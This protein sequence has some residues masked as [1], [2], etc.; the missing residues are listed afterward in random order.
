[1]MINATEIENQIEA[2]RK[3]KEEIL[4]MSLKNRVDDEFKE[5]FKIKILPKINDYKIKCKMLRQQSYIDSVFET[6]LTQK[7]GKEYADIIVDRLRYCYK[8]GSF[9]RM[10]GVYPKFKDDLEMRNL[11]L[12]CSAVYRYKLV[13]GINNHIWGT[14][15]TTCKSIMKYT[16]ACETCGSIAFDILIQMKKLNFI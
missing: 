10:L 8:I 2:L 3:R 11:V 15:A 16:A 5:S 9:S 12:F 7:I 13:T 14:A 4:N 6:L 1:M